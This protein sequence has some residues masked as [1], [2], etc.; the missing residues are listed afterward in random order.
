MA[1]GHNSRSLCDLRRA[2]KLVFGPLFQ[3]LSLQNGAFC[4]YGLKSV[5]VHT[6]RLGGFE[7]TVETTDLGRLQGLLSRPRGHAC[8]HLRRSPVAVSTVLGF[9]PNDSRY[10]GRSFKAVSFGIHGINHD[11]RGSPISRAAVPGNCREPFPDLRRH[12]K[13]D[14]NRTRRLIE[15]AKPRKSEQ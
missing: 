9:S 1:S 8:R 2:W 15:A 13:S 3:G 4:A 12:T 10:S 7:S 6:L 5:R 11:P 14:D